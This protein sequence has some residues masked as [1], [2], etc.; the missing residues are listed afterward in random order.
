MSIRYKILLALTFCLLSCLGSYFIIIKIFDNLEAQLYDKC[1]IEALTG[2]RIMSEVMHFMIRQKVLTEDE[3]FDVNYTPIPDSNPRKYH[4]KYD[5]VFD[6]WIQNIQ[7]EFLLDTDV[8]YAI[9][10]DRNGYVPT[11]NTK[12]SQPETKVYTT[13][14]ARSRT[15]R[16]FAN[17]PGIEKIIRYRGK[18]TIQV[19]YQRDTG[20][21]MWNIGSAVIVNGKHWGS[22]MVGVSL[23]RVEKIKSQM[24]MLVGITMSVIFATT[25]LAI[26]A[27]LPRKYFPQDLDV[28]RF[29]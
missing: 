14:L 15:K 28:S 22:F 4:T 21:S 16:L 1:R 13:D 29:K 11:H 27:I 2:A 26:L 23:E 17:Y 7:D 19:L 18:G 25:L 5:K 6:S 20:E 24:L 8:D 3:L 9:L 10:I 12:Y